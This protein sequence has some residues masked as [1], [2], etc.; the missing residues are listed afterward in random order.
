M[1][2][3]NGSGSGDD[4]LAVCEHRDPGASVFTNILRAVTVATAGVDGIW[5]RQAWHCLLRWL[6]GLIGLPVLLL[7]VI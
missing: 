4:H 1:E 3:S 6:A 5:T 7:V 2:S